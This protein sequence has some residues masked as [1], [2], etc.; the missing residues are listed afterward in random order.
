L[1]NKGVYPYDYI[2]LFNKFNEIQLPNK[3]AFYNHLYEDN[4]INKN[5]KRTQ[6]I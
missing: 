4:I 1:T 3:E 2:N 6:L 5:Y